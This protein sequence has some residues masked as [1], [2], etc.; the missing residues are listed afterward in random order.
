V[1][2]QAISDRIIILIFDIIDFIADFFLFE[3]ST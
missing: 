1:N 2:A 3:L